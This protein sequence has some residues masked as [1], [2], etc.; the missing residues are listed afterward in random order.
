MKST[1]ATRRLKKAFNK[2]IVQ[3]VVNLET[4]LDEIKYLHNQALFYA[5][6]KF[7]VKFVMMRF[8]EC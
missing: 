6:Q 7:G 4:L 1:T 2:L 5:L 3:H 8:I